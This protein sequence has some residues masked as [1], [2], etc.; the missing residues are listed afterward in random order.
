MRN[1]FLI[2]LLIIA[3][4]FGRPTSLCAQTTYTFSYTG[5]VQYFT[6]PSGVASVDLKTWGAQGANSLDVSPGLHSGGLGSLATGTL[7]VTPGQVLSIYVG[8][9]GSSSGG[10]GYNGGGSAGLSSAGGGCSG[11]YAGGGGGASDVRTGA[12]TLTDRVIVG[13]GGGGAGR[14][15]CNGGCTPCGWGGS[16]GAGDI[17][18]SPAASGGSSINYGQKGTTGGPGS[19][20]PGDGGGPA[21]STG[22]FGTGGAGAG[23]TYDVAAGGGGGGYYGGGGG[24]SA[25]S[26]SGTGGG[27]GGGGSSYTGGVSSGVV[28]TNVQSGNGQVQVILSCSAGTITGTTTVCTGLTTPL[29]DAIS[30]GAWTSANTSVA[31]VSGSGV[32]TGVTAGTATISYGG[33]LGCGTAYATATVT[34]LAPPSAITGTA[35]VCTGGTTAL[36]D[37]GGGT[38][39]SSNTSVATVNTVGTV[40]ALSAGTSAITYT[41]GGCVTSVTVTV[42]TLPSAPAV[43]TGS[44]SLCAGGATTSL[45]DATAGGV[46]S[47]TNTSAATVGVS[48]LVTSVAAGT[49]TIS[50]TLSN[51]CG[52]VASTT[53]VTVSALPVS[54]APITG[55]FTLCA[56]GATTPLSDATAG[57]TWTSISTTVAAVSGTGVVTGLIAG[58]STISYTMTTSCGSLAATVVV[59]VNPLPITPAAITGTLTVCAGSTTALSDATAGGAWTSTSTS[60]ATVS[61]TGL[62]TGLTAGTT[63]ISYTYTNACG[64]IAATKVVTVNPL[65]V[66]PAAIT[67]TFT[68]CAGGATT[69][70]S[71]A[72]SGG[73]WTST[74]TTVA[75]VSGTGTVTGLIAGTSTISYTYTTACGSLASTVVV[76]VNPLPVTPAAIT[77]TLTVCAGGAT[78][79]LSDATAG[80]AWTSTSTTVATVSGTGLVTG[81]TAGTTTISYTYTNS[82]GSIA[83]TRVVTVNP[84]PVTPAAITGTF[85]VCAGGATT[86][87]SDATAGGNWTSISTTVATVG[88]TGIVTGLIAGTSTISYTYTTACGSIAA[89]VVVTVNPLPITPAAITGTLTM[90]AGGGTTALSDATAGGAWTSTSTTVATVSGAGLVTGLT[91]G[92][93]TISYTYTT[94]CGSIAA[95]VVVTVN[96]LPI[97]PGAITGTFTVCAS[98]AT[99]ALSDATAG[100]AWSSTNTTVATISGTGLV[101]GLTP[102]TTTIS[103]TYTTVCGSI[104]SVATVTVNPLPVAPAAITGTTTLCAG[105]ATTALSDATAGGTWTSTNTTVATVSGTGLVTGAAAGTATISYTYT[106]SCGSL[107]ATT[108][109]TVNPLPTLPAAITGIATVC[110][111]ATT[112]LSDVTAGGV[113]SS[114]NTTVAT[115]GGT[116]LVTGLIVGTSAISYTYTNSCG[117]LAATKVVTVNPLPITPGAITGTMIVCAS[118][119]T[120]ALTDAT[121]G[122]TWT[123][124]STTVAT[125][126]GSGIVTGIIAGTTT[127]SYTYTNSCGS[128]AATATVTVNPMPIVPAAITGLAHTCELGGTAILSDATAGGVWSSTNTGVATAGAG[129]LV[130]G[131]SVGTSVISYTYTNSCGSA[132]AI[133]VLTV[134]P[135]PAAGTITGPSTMCTTFTITLSDATPGGSWSSGAPGIASVGGT[136]GVVT[137]FMAGSAPISYSVTSFCG[138]ATAVKT[139][140]VGTSPVVDTIIAEGPTTICT[141]GTVQLS[142]ATPGGAWTNGSGTLVTLTSTGLV[143]ATA[144]GTARIYY[145]LTN[146]CGSTVVS[147]NITIVAQPSAGTISG[148]ATVCVGATL[149]L[150][151]NAAGGTWTSSNAN[152]LITSPGHVK[153]M[154]AGTDTIHYKV[155]NFCGSD[156]V[157]KTIT[158]TDCSHTGVHA[159]GNSPA[160]IKVLPNPNKGDFEIEGSLGTTGDAQVSIEVTDMVGHTLYTGKATAV[161]GSLHQHISLGTSPASGTY[162]LSV[163]S[164]TSYNVFHVVV[165]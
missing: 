143:T 24:G 139:I 39:T 114:V 157:Q 98:G 71:D 7:A 9:A 20:G 66:A 4:I 160:E 127:I 132:A 113:W 54:P 65:P 164:A 8:G 76:T 141:S 120:T 53:V 134:S 62:V 150:T 68:V 14:D 1:L 156:S 48:G 135:L 43:I 10:G 37:A 82:C 74:T 12:Y 94:A 88:A 151:D 58:T 126:T 46:W 105:G 142:D 33:T 30:G 21:G 15:Y 44:A 162:I 25:S 106:N 41:L 115:V 100:G 152:G 89:T 103:Y 31:T 38:W 72:T 55:T 59:T 81:L 101:T 163:R 42:S 47:S 161:N 36:T 112:A 158:I 118:G 125:V 87:L 67:G 136:S 116:G 110:T 11:G 109:L 80:G 108:L 60:V 75:T 146:T 165:E 32:V 147:K 56:G 138:L 84:L 149:V 69:A 93:S 86:N 77:G 64:S 5:S 128:I 3:A 154:T 16:G 153:G 123:S 18:G 155:V 131:L 104:A 102:G 111:G 13:A 34:V 121:A 70:L 129:G 40:T 23:G 49:S 78:T 148:A 92:T 122:G 85:T 45:S 140:T 99:T 91:A 96:P 28:S 57:G 17:N 52:S 130:T 159:A 26:G 90:C 119:S 61:G 145:S 107:A 19:G 73:A 137:G 51:S 124:T 79:A 35:T 6:V 2:H 95:T 29:T 27:G 97:T 83:A 63:T 117:T 144:A 133:V 22:S 50:Y